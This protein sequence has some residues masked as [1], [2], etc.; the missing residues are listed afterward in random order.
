M[1][2]VNYRAPS[3]TYRVWHRQANRGNPQLQALS[4]FSQV[5]FLTGCKQ[6]E[7]YSEEIHLSNDADPG[8]SSESG[9]E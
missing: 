9:R 2:P 6:L 5:R 4:L 3:S 8:F 7:N 1:T